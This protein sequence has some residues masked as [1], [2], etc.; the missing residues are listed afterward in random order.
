MHPKHFTTTPNFKIRLLGVNRRA[1]HEIV[2][3]IIY[4]IS[5]SIKADCHI[6]LKLK[7]ELFYSQFSSLASFNKCNDTAFCTR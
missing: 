3:I 7:V 6:N 4:A 2:Y 5:V 1:L